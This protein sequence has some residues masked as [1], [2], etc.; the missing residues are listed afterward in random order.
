[1]LPEG[2]SKMS[3]TKILMKYYVRDMALYLVN[4]N[5]SCFSLK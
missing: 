4:I 1:M 5:C 3:Q 2:L